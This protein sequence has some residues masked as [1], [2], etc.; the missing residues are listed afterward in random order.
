MHKHSTLTIII[1]RHILYCLKYYIEYIYDD[2]DI[3]NR[4]LCDIMSVDVIEV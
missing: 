1:Q 4:Q 3:I 2:G